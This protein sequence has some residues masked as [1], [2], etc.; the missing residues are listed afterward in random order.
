MKIRI[1]K[2]DGV[3]INGREELKRLFE[4]AGD[5]DYIVSLFSLA[6]PHSAE[7]WRK[8]YFHLRDFLFESTDTGYTKAGLHDAIKDRILSELWHDEGRM[9]WFIDLTNDMDKVPN[10]TKWLSTSG[11]REFIRRFK[12]LSQDTFDIYI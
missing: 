11:W 12:E 1:T 4:S 5:G 7:E 6:E 8:L 10:S 3:I 9:A 2:K